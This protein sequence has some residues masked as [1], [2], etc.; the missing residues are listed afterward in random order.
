V[1]SVN[2]LAQRPLQVQGEE[3]WTITTEQG[4]FGRV[5]GCCWPG[6]LSV[7]AELPATSAPLNRV[8]DQEHKS[9]RRSRA[10]PEWLSPTK[11]LPNNNNNTPTTKQKTKKTTEKPN[12]S[13]GTSVEDPVSQDL[14]PSQSSLFDGLSASQESEGAT[15]TNEDPQTGKRKRSEDELSDEIK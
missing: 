15:S 7:S 1:P 4:G 5:H 10:L 14:Q 11:S 3:A 13:D 9:P 12:L 2:S 8:L 6:S